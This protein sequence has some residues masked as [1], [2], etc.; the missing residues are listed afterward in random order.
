MSEKDSPR[1]SG[2][3][4]QPTPFTLTEEEKSVLLECRRNSIARGIPLG[5]ATVIAVRFFIRSGMA[6]F[7]VQRWSLFYYTG[8]F[9][10]SFM[11]GV[12]S[13]REKCFQK[14]MALENSTLKQQVIDRFYSQQSPSGQQVGLEKDI[15]EEPSRSPRRR[16]KKESR[17]GSTAPGQGGDNDSENIRDGLGSSQGVDVRSEDSS[18]VL[19]APVEQ[20]TPTKRSRTFDE[21]RQENRRRLR[22]KAYDE[23]ATD[24]GDT[25]RRVE[26][27]TPS[28]LT[29]SDQSGKILHKNKYGDIE[30]RDK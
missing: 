2:Q 16:V 23:P 10:L 27:S 22:Q 25:W 26:D 8:G 19:G 4:G 7:H 13:Y 17:L 30:Y 15:D 3:R 12:G 1:G 28:N 9:L 29:Q 11:A 24:E 20:T 18:N 5:I 21:I 14:I 6:P